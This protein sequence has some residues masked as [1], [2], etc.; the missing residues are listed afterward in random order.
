MYNEELDDCNEPSL[1]HGSQAE[2][3]RKF[4]AVIMG[5]LGLKTGIILSLESPVSLSLPEIK[6]AAEL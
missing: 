2:F 3:Y 6:P 4:S 5:R 1:C